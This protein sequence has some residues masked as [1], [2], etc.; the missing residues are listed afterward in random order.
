[1]NQEIVKQLREW[2]SKKAKQENVE[3]YLVMQNKTI[4]AIAEVLPINKEEFVA[5]KGL[6]EKKYE[7][8]GQEIIAI[9]THG[10]NQTFQQK[11]LND[12]KK[13]LSVGDFLNLVNFHLG[14]LVVAVKGEISSINIRQNYL[15]FTIKD[16]E[17]ECSMDC[18]MWMSD[19][20]LAG[21]T[22]EEGMEIVIHGY[23][24]IY[25]K[26]GRFTFRSNAVELVGE[27]ILKKRYEELKRKLLSEGF[28]DP[29]RKK[30]LPNLP[31][32]VGLIT[33]RDGAVIHD[34]QSNL[35]RFGFKVKFIDSR[36]EG[37]LAIRELVS[38][39][40]Y[41]RRS[42]IDL[43]VIIRGGGSLES[44]QAFNNEVLIREI[45]NYPVPVVCGIGHDKDVPLFALA[46]DKAFSTPTAVARELNR[47]WEQSVE[48]LRY[49]QE[50]IINKYQIQLKI[51][52]HYIEQVF[53]KTKEYY[54]N[55]LKYFERFNQVAEKIFANFDYTIGL[56]RQRVEYFA[57]RL[58]RSYQQNLNTLGSRIDSF[59]KNIEQNNPTRQ[60]KLGYSLV[61]YKD[62]IIR[63]ISQI[64]PS[65][66]LKIKL[67]D[68]NIVSEIKKIEREQ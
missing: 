62:K 37:A 11:L 20:E 53:S 66:L 26:N 22:L 5:I 45:T 8:Y 3:L 68:G 44:L 50:N 43:L 46:A 67:S 7:K 30:S 54:Y 1:M 9:V 10:D 32:R 47:S 18:F 28:F 24:E 59:S 2:R 17:K 36:V 60:L 23:P 40:R 57:E 33:S 29:E 25:A 27:G 15:F 61:F 21:I 14:E 41:F 42:K 48:K 16:S 13:V 38:A 51:K 49:Y 39:I 55:L 12:A 58:V 34:F 56:S 65:D 6:G 4:E 64:E 19:Y 31:S 63:S 52:K 35:G